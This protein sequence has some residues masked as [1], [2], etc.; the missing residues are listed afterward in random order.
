M[1]KI[2]L[3]FKD[4]SEKQIKENL[5][6]SESV[7]IVKYAKLPSP[8]LSSLRQSLRGINAQL[9]VVKNS[10]ARRAIKDSSLSSLLAILEGPCGMVFIR[11]EPVAASRLLCNFSRE[12]EQLKLEGG[13]LNDRILTKNDIEA[14][15][16]LPPKEMLR[17]Q[18]VIA[19]KAPI[20]G[21]VMVLHQALQK[22]VYCLDQIKEKK[23]TVDSPQPTDKN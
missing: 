19:L 15:A 3:L 16:K 2:G 14:L 8:D 13:F 7:F 11:S 10:V 6:E 1:K 18:A 23:S 17:L 22:F 5:K 20:S 12:H 4:I 21:L 9:F